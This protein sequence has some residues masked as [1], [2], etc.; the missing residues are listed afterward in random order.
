MWTLRKR[1]SNFF[2][3]IKVVV[4]RVQ[5]K[6]NLALESALKILFYWSTVG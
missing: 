6:G 1:L 4:G 5:I 2:K 3:V